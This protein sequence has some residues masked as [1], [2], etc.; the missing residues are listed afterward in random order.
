MLYF[1]EGTLWA[2]LSAGNPLLEFT[3]G[4]TGPRCQSASSSVV[5][6]LQAWRTPADSFSSKGKWG[7]SKNCSPAWLTLEAEQT[8]KNISQVGISH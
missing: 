8:L 4:R 7:G 2:G 3:D 5:P 6:T 1:V